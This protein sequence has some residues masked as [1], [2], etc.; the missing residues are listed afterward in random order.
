MSRAVAASSVLCL[1]VAVL[2]LSA[3]GQEVPP[4]PTIIR[5]P[6][7]ET[8]SPG[9]TCT[10]TATPAETPASPTETPIP[11]SS[12]TST[13]TPT[14]S[15]APAP[16]APSTTTSPSLEGRFVFQVAS[17]GDIY[18]VNADG[19]GLTR[20]TEG[21]DPSWS[22]D[23]SKLAVARWTTPWGIYTINADGSGEKLLF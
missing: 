12:P 5:L 7:E 23:G 4:E 14:L 8:P 10:A 16:Q 22:P 6:V 15:A 13:P 3:C 9:L 18:L 2:L 17:G 20:L 11:T 19:T 1:V 21:M